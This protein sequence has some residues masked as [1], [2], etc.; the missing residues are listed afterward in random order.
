MNT[1]IIFGQAL[2]ACKENLANYTS[3]ELYCE[4]AR[5]AVDQL[6][7]FLQNAVCWAGV[8][9]YALANCWYDT[10]NKT[11]YYGDYCFEYGGY[12]GQTAWVGLTYLIVRNLGERLIGTRNR[13]VDL[14]AIQEDLR[15]LNLGQR[16]Y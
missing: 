11:G 1:T 6:P 4:T 7:S 10:F 14:T 13:D 9:S 5:H 15:E 3:G 16:S 2:N 8:V 12:V